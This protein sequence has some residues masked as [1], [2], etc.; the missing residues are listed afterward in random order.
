MID[1]YRLINHDWT[2]INHDWS[3]KTDNYD[4]STKIDLSFDQSWM[5]SHEWSIMIESKLI[6]IEKSWL[7]NQNGQLWFF[8]N[9]D[10]S[11]MIAQSWLISHDWSIKTD[12][13]FIKQDRSINWSIMIDQSY[14]NPNYWS[15][16]NDQSWLITQN[17]FYFDPYLE[18][19]GW[20][21]IL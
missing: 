11:V 16:M 2:K 4:L 1:Q 10:W 8:F 13:D 19:T 14:L 12:N 9:Q 5:N 17:G 20:Q 21:K 7:I 6:M 15:V 18:G 3:F